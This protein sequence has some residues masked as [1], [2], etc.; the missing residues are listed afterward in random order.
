MHFA[1]HKKIVCI[2][3]QTIISVLCLFFV[4]LF[5][6]PVF[7]HAFTQ[8]KELFFKITLIFGI[9]L[10]GYKIIKER[11]LKVNNIF[12]APLCI[13]LL[14]YYAIMFITSALSSTP[15][16]ALHGTMSRGFGIITQGFLLI[17]ILYIALS[18]KEKQIHRLLKVLTAS[19]TLIALYAYAQMAGIDPFFK[20]YDTNIF[21]GRAFST[22]GNPSYLGQYLLL[23]SIISSYL[24]FNAQ[25]RKYKL[26]YA[27]STFIML[28]GIVFSG[29]RTALLA[30]VC[31]LILSLIAFAK[32]L[33]ISCVKY[34]KKIWLTIILFI[35]LITSL[36]FTALPSERFSFSPEALRSLYSRIEIWKGALTL[37]K[38]QPL[39]GYGQETFYLHAPT[40][41][42]KEFLTREEDVNISI[43]RIHNEFLETFFSSGLM[44]VL[45]YIVIFAYLIV[46]CISKKNPL[47][48]T[49]CLIV[50]A[51]MLQNQFSFSDI[52]ISILVAFCLGAI[53]AL[54]SG[55][56]HLKFSKKIKGLSLALY[57]AS[58]L[59]IALLIIPKCIDIARAER[60]F[61]QSK[62]YY[63]RDYE[64]AVVLHKNATVYTPYYG[65]LWY[66]LMFID[67]SSMDRAL[68]YLDQIEGETGNVLAWHGNRF[69]TTDPAR[70]A[71]YYQAALVKNPQYPNWIRAYAEMLYKHGDYKNAL[72]LYEKYLEAVPDFWKWKDVLSDRT[73]K[74]RQSY[75]VFNKHVPYFWLIVERV[76]ELQEYQRVPS[77]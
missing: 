56:T 66:E 6:M 41:I 17:W 62:Y 4:P 3:A 18:I 5:V 43:D 11:T 70:A 39:Q 32:P 48:K 12:N 24:F 27:V 59:I 73:E 7:L 31:V 69:A 52:S 54:S 38:K 72:F 60:A 16:V 15:I 65:E 9:L 34:S 51:N 46:I 29:T 53:I 61:A 55:A 63:T 47:I 50:I 25:L 14:V 58:F 57:A 42:T 36:A 35:A 74:E 1:F 49:L 21:V 2:E 28:G 64:T 68:H 45:M 22:L 76:K 37:I 77:R 30:L 23:T 75:E 71:T 19:G 40:I 13:L 10:W 20:N 44:G 26:L 33:I 8:G 67:T